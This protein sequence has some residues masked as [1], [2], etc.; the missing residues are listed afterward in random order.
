MKKSWRNKKNAGLTLLE[1]IVAVSIFSVAALV[2]L[3]G[4]VLSGRINSKSA[5]Y[6]SATDLAQNIMEDIKSKS[7]PELSLAFNYPEDADTKELRLS[8]LSSQK[9]RYESGEMGIQ[10]LVKD[11]EQYKNVR[12]YRPSDTDTSQVTA[13]VISEDNGRTYKFNAR[14]K[15]KNESKY[16]FELTNVKGEKQDYDV[17]AEFD[18]G[19]DS[20]YKKSSSSSADTE[21]NDY[22][23]PNISKLDT[24]TNAFLIMPKNWDDNAMTELVKAQ[25]QQA[26]KLAAENK[27]EE[28]AT[29]DPDE[30]YKYT[31]RTLYVRVEESGGTIKA[32]AKYT[33][34]A[35]DYVSDTDPVYG[36]MDLCPKHNGTGSTESC[37]YESAYTPFYSSETGDELKSI[38]V[39]YYPNYNSTSSVNPLDEVVFENTSNYPVNLYVTKQREEGTGD[40]GNTE[41]V[42]VP[43]SAQ[44]NTYRMSLTVRECPDALGKVNWNTNPGLYRAK[45]A[46]RTN[47]DYNISDP[48]K[49]LERPR[50]NQMK[51]TYQA[52]STSG[53]DN[54]KVTGSSAKKVL[55]YNGLDDRKTA[56]RIYKA[57]VSIY[58]AGAAE[59][60]FP[61]SDRICT[62][63]GA[64]EQ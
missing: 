23:A 18:G 46:L 54:K 48:D 41:T 60:N 34:N 62:L 8:S 43:T 12:K 19:K 42:S 10:E 40:S 47:L 28:P 63:D 53:V 57:K 31:K 15:G 26:Q 38:Y 51:L 13:S 50:I 64:K 17:L 21:K 49:V 4:F 44:E 7:F 59:K 36:R 22:L 6:M 5:L 11:G 56:D 24:K 1:V 14:T 30:V 3:Q 39:F 20:G 55:S 52:V 37:T 61:E 9:D 32:E 27:E 29:L 33:L 2:L 35:Y 16:Y 45:T 58:K 25:H